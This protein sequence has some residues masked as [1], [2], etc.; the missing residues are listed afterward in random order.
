MFYDYSRLISYNSLISFVLGERG[1]GKTYGA[2]KLCIND[3]LK[4]GH[5]FVYLRRYA[6]ELETS[7]PKFF[8]AIIENGEYEEHTFKIKKNKRL[9]MFMIDGK[10]AGYAVPLSTSIILKSTSFAS[11]R[12]IIFDEFIID[13]GTYHYLNSECE[14]FLDLIET[15]GRLR[16]IRVFCLANAISISNPYFDYFNLSIPYKSE[17]K[18]CKRDKNGNPLILINY[19]K[20]EEYRTAKRESRFGQ[21]IDGTEYGQYAID[22]EFLRDDSTFIEKRPAHCKQYSTINVNN[23]DYGVWRDH[24]TE[25]IYVCKDFDPN[26]PCYFTVDVDWH[27]DNTILVSA[28]RSPW[29]NILI[30]AFRVGALRFENQKIKNE[31]L[32]ILRRCLR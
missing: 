26:H 10:V 2:I 23:H 30:S 28:R 15:I 20:N 27:T 32:D 29:F 7:V 4:N 6:T 22:N 18:V 25:I 19:I 14:K 11:V 8:D 16:D 12:T 13:H 3:F 21:L 31:M 1:V 5:Q 17:F 24:K 9:S